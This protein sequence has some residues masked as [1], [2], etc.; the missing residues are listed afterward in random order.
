MGPG[1]ERIAEHY[2]FDSFCKKELI[3]NGI[4][5]YGKDIRGQLPA[6]SAGD[7]PADIARFCDTVK[8]HARD[9]GRS[10]YTFGRMPDISRC[11][12]TLRTGDISS[13]TSAAERTMENGLCPDPDDHAYS[14]MLRRKPA[15]C[16][17]D[18]S[19]FDHAETL[20]GSILRYADVPERE[21][22]QHASGQE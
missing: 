20:Y 16:K 21:L 17:A 8:K 22:G 1:G 14:L 12:Y 5:L 11:L 6:P 3:Q 2:A 9:T 13:K 7:L 19:V 10:L 4:R 15:R 18:P